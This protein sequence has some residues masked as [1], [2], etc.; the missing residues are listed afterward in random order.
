MIVNMVMV[1]LVRVHCCDPASKVWLE[2]HYI[3]MSL[4]QNGKEANN[5]L[6]FC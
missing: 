2:L 4:H 3:Y 5:A 6:L 1:S